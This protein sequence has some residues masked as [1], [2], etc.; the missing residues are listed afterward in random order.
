MPDEEVVVPDVV[1]ETEI[2]QSETESVTEVSDSV[3]MSVIDEMAAANGW[4]P[5]GELNSLDFMHKAKDFRDRQHSTLKQRNTD[6]DDLKVEQ[7]KLYTL[8]AE[9]INR[10]DRTAY[11]SEQKEWDTTRTEAIERG[12]VAEVNRLDTNRPVAPQAPPNPAHN[13]NMTFINNWRADNEWFDSDKP[14]NNM[15][16][17]FYQAEKIRTGSDDPQT[18]LPAVE[19]MM[20][21]AY[22]AYF[23]TE[24][25]P[26]PNADLGAGVETGGKPRK[27]KEKG[28]QRSGLDADELKH[29][30]QFVAGGADP[31]EL[32]KYI[33]EG[34]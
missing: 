32:L 22:P 21:Q 8:M 19:K 17:G 11:Q 34:R 26:N 23:R 12:D 4:K 33:E 3:P 18:I 31:K 5:D 30:D 13:E 7:A 6:I 25:D 9:G 15:A 29:F 28:L 1:V 10:Q 16:L 24:P 20:K 27:S 14:M 2:G